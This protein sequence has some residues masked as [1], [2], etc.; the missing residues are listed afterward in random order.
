[1]HACIRTYLHYITLHY[2]ALHC[3][4]LHCIALHCI[5]L[6]YTH[7]HIYIHTHIY[8]Y[9]YTHTH[10]HIHIYL[11]IYILAQNRHYTFCCG[12]HLTCKNNPFNLTGVG[13][14]K[15]LKN[16]ESYHRHSQCKLEWSRSWPFPFNKTILL[17]TWQI[18]KTVQALKWPQNGW[19]KVEIGCEVVLGLATSHDQKVKSCRYV[20]MISPDILPTHE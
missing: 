20:G 18:A 1:M 5:A 16:S 15:D 8:I 9:T 2:I 3:T 7:I 19:K 4:A 17:P 14:W 12:V 11:H 13:H 10:I 6:H